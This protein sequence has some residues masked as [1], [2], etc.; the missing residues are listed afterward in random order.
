M[1][2]YPPLTG[3]SAG[4][5]GWSGSALL[6]PG[7]ISDGIA[8][9]G[10]ALIQVPMQRRAMEAQQAKEDYQQARQSRQDDLA[11]TLAN[12][13]IGDLQDQ[14]GERTARNK[15]SQQNA[16]TEAARVKAVGEHAS[17]EDSRKWAEDLGTAVENGLGDLGIGR[18]A[19]GQA[20]QPK[21]PASTTMTQAPAST[22]MTQAQASAAALRIAKAEVGKYGKVDPKRVDQLTQH[23]LGTD[24]EQQ[25]GD[26]LAH[27]GEPGPA[28]TAGGLP[29]ATAV[30]P[31]P[32]LG[33]LGGLLSSPAITTYEGPNVKPAGPP[34][35]LRGAL[36]PPPG[37]MKARLPAAA[38]SKGT[39]TRA[40]L[41]QAVDAGAFPDIDA[42]AADAQRN[43]FTVA[44]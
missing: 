17:S 43:G 12:A 16:D 21:A 20:S 29:G 15:I 31:G 3:S 11:E 28:A 35:P 39:L 5:S 34:D 40:H 6:V 13:R 42:A 27:P 38:T 26:A 25:L 32:H 19:K 18:K 9:L 22:T 8:E 36:M 44:P 24:D 1:R 37:A 30:L 7:G 23:L 10:K 2:A 4:R 14:R 41:Q 33:N